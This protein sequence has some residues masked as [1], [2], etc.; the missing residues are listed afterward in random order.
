[1]FSFKKFRNYCWGMIVR[2]VPTLKQVASE[3]SLSYPFAAYFLFGL[4]YGLFALVGYFSGHTAAG[5]LVNFISAKDYYLWEGLFMIPITM[6]IYLLFAALAHLF[7]RLLGGKGSFEATLSVL[8][9]TY[10]IPLIVLFWIPDVLFFSF[11][12]SSVQLTLVPFYGTAAGLWTFL[13]SVIG[14][15]LA[16]QLSFPRALLVTTLSIGISFA[17]LGGLLIR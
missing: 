10:S 15:K 11:F 7:A 2:P 6:Q 1:M 3:P 4:L 5:V 16:Q 9:F 14:I 12:G 17:F 8:G 13:V